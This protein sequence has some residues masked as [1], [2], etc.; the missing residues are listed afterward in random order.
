MTV[1]AHKETLG[2]Q[3]EVKQLLHLMIHSL[4][5]NKEIFLREL[6]SYA[7]E[8]VDKLRSEGLSYD[9]LCEGDSEFDIHYGYEKDAVTSNIF[10]N[11]N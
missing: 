1:E 3:T 2:F 4:Y 10:T 7:S 9:A 5:S 8:A 6:F 11:G